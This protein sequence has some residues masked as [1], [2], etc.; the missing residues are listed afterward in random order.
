MT[1]SRR[2]PLWLQ[3]L[4][5]RAAM[6]VLLWAL[7]LD[8]VLSVL[9]PADA[10]LPQ[11]PAALDAIEAVSDAVTRTRPLRTACLERALVRYGLL[12]G[13]GYPATFVVGVCSGGADGFQAH[14][15]VTLDDRP[16]MERDPVVYRPT[17]VWPQPAP[18]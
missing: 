6:P 5:L 3:A 18:G 15:W 16:I 12:R 9:T 8:R 2:L 1:G 17:F 10:P 7:P 14:A 13:Q 11:P 4:Q